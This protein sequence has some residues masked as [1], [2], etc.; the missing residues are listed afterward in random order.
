MY[1]NIH[2]VAIFAHNV[3][4]IIASPV[5]GCAGKTGTTL[6][7]RNTHTVAIFANNFEQTI[8]KKIRETYKH[9]VSGNKPVSSA[10]FFLLSNKGTKIRF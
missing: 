10:P 1:T 7:Y 5:L 9:D 4:Q 8:A 6:M 3:R 2:T